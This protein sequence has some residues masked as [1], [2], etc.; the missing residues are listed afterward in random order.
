MSAG[1]WQILA[2]TLVLAAWLFVHVVTVVRVLRA[3]S[4]PRACKCWSLVV[5]VA[6][7]VAWR[8][9]ERRVSVLWLALALCYVGM[10]SFG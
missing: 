8:S 4:V 3:P 2:W 1:A 6:P 9:G 10:R 5:P 7:L